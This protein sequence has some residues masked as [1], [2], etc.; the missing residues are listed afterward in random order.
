MLVVD[1]YLP[2]SEDPTQLSLFHSEFSQRAEALLNGQLM[3]EGEK[4][5]SA[6]PLRLELL[7]RGGGGGGGEGGLEKSF[8]ILQISARGVNGTRLPRAI[9]SLLRLDP[10]RHLVTVFPERSRWRPGSLNPPE[11]PKTK[12]VAIPNPRH[13]LP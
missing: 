8:T 6:P 4:S 11:D 2:H 3:D 5:D 10:P 7:S 13:P 1:G 12:E 9:G